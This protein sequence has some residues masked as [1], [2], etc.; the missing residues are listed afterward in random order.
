VFFVR[1]QWNLNV[2]YVG[3]VLKYLHIPGTVTGI[4]CC[5]DEQQYALR[6]HM[7]C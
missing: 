4:L 3:L 5:H 1:K 2:I 6:M 7:L